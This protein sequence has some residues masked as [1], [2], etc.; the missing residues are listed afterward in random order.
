[1]VEIHALYFGVIV[2]RREQFTGKEAQR[3]QGRA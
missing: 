1:M 3:V 2:Q